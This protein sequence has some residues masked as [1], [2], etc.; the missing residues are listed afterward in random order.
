MR[1]VRSEGSISHETSPG[2]A[3]LVMLA[4]LE[5]DLELAIEEIR[6]LDRRSRR[7]PLKRTTTTHRKEFAS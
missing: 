3:C 4:A 2:L 5:K 7:K 6:R 1:W